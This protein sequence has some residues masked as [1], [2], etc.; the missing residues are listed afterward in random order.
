MDGASSGHIPAL[1]TPAVSGSDPRAIETF[2]VVRTHLLAQS[3]LGKV[4]FEQVSPIN[5]AAQLASHFIAFGDIPAAEALCERAWGLII[6]LP[7]QVVT[8]ATGER[9]NSVSY[10]IEG[11][12]TAKMAT[13]FI[14]TGRLLSFGALRGEGAPVVDNEYIGALISTTQMLSRYAQAQATLG[15]V[16]S[17]ALCRDLTMA[18]NGKMIQFDLRNGSLRR[19]YDGLK[20]QLKRLEELLYEQSLIGNEAPQSDPKLQAL[21][22]F[23]P[24]I[25]AHLAPSFGPPHLTPAHLTPHI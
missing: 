8:P 25:P 6:G 2:E 3:N 17:V 18:V 13:H 19:K 20:Y 24:L 11:L 9:R 7:P 12:I 5:E 21:H 1:P 15:D 23:G 4:I 14:R 22:S 10:A 16:R